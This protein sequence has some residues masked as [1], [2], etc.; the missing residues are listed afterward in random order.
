MLSM[1]V[2]QVLHRLRCRLRPRHSKLASPP[3]SSAGQA[4]WPG[5]FMGYWRGPTFMSASPSMAQKHR[6]TSGSTTLGDRQGVHVSAPGASKKPAPH[7]PVRLGPGH[8]PTD[9]H[10]LLNVIL[11]DGNSA[12][13]LRAGGQRVRSRSEALWHEPPPC[14]QP[15][16]AQQHCAQQEDRCMSARPETIACHMLSAR[17]FAAAALHGTPRFA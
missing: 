9:G 5:S 7:L 13:V 3:T 12:I 11:T 8:L 17:M 2:L 16:Q 1:Q 14:S 15:G 4:S 10:A 6:V